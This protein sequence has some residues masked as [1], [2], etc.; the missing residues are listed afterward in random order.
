MSDA[1]CKHCTVIRH[2]RNA[3]HAESCASAT[4]CG[5]I[6]SNCSIVHELTDN[7]GII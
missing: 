7:N 5:V 6:V 2:F 1:H 3:N 4:T